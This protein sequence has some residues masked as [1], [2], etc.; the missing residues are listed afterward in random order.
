MKVLYVAGTPDGSK[1]L[2]ESTEVTELQLV[3]HAS[4]LAVHEFIAL[5]DLPLHLLPDALNR[6]QPDIVHF[7]AH[8]E[9]NVLKLRDFAN[10]PVPVDAEMLKQLISSA[11]SPASLLYFN[12]CN[13][14]LLAKGLSKSIPSIGFEGELPNPIAR[15]AAVLFYQAVMRGDSLEQAYRATA[16]YV[17]VTGREKGI[18]C[19]IE[20]SPEALEQ[21]LYVP[22]TIVAKAGS[23]TRNASVSIIRLGIRGVPSNA[24]KAVLCIC[25]DRI[26]QDIQQ[27]IMDS[28][29]ERVLAGEF[30][31]I[32]NPAPGQSEIWAESPFRASVS[33]YALAALLLNDGSS[34]T[35]TATLSKALIGGKDIEAR[36]QKR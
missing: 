33:S 13:S 35:A 34:V 26:E 7:A 22:L 2:L 29:R 15:H 23:T 31:R 8:G 32:V 14:A 27:M 9:G 24:K 17:R 3:F 30:C 12:A 25:E 20:G 4:G 36:E 16:D 10:Q 5:P 21:R 18:R 19:V 1:M 6:F 11:A 28:S